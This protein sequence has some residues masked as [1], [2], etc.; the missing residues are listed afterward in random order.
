MYN[1]RHSLAVLGAVRQIGF[2]IVAKLKSP[3][4]ILPAICLSIAP[5][6]EN[7]FVSSS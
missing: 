6:I 1:E 7:S 4:A 2:A 5:A 3:L